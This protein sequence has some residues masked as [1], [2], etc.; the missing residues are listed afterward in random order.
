MEEKT[1]RL[2]SAA[3][4]MESALNDFGPGVNVEVRIL[5]TS[6]M[7]MPGVLYSVRLTMRRDPLPI[8]P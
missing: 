6:T 4:E 7:M 5:D 2:R 8:Y 3:K 1:E